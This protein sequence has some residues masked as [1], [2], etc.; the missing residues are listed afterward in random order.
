[1]ETINTVESVIAAH[2]VSKTFVTSNRQ[3]INALKSIN[4]DIPENSFT[5]IVGPSG[6]GKSTLLR[7]MA[8]L[9]KCSSGKIVYRNKNQ[10][11]PRKEIGMIFQEYS[12]FP[13]RTILDNV[14]MGMEFA[15]KNIKIRKEKGAKYL[16]LVGLSQYGNVFP[17]ELS[18]GMRQRVAIA[19]ALANDPDVL[20]MDEPF[21]AVDAYTRI[22]LQKRLLNIWQKH[23]KTIV[24]ITHSVD[25]AVFLA[26]TIIVMSTN[27]GGILTQINVPLERPRQRDNPEYAKLVVSILG[28]L[29]QESSEDE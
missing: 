22:L 25:E 7:I 8:G 17:Y 15:K 9:E 29:E 5:V 13:W 2:D 1:M 11:K 3:I 19:R 14:C 6:C 21:G 28:M 12:L 24:F 16:S 4:L 27:P 20:L 23:K 18:G 26:D 10:E